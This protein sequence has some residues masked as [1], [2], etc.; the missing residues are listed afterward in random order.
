MVSA[1]LYTYGTHAAAIEEGERA[2][3]IEVRQAQR[4]A[5]ETTGRANVLHAARDLPDRA[6]TQ[7]RHHSTPP[8]SE[9]AVAPHPVPPPE[10]GPARKAELLQYVGDMELD[11]IGADALLPGNDGIGHA[12]ADALRHAPLRWGQYV[13]MRRS[14]ARLRDRHDAMSSALPHD[15]PYPWRGGVAAREGSQGPAKDRRYEPTGVS[16][17]M[18]WGLGQWSMIV[19]FRPSRLA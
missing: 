9:R 5:V 13:L 17:G 15:F 18:T 11:R 2:I 8:C 1:P 7:V 16:S 3:G 12:V 14:S 19:R 10:F 4:F 6:E